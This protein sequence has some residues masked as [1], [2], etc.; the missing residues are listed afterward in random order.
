MSNF[1]MF[2]FD[3][4]PAPLKIRIQT[5]K[6]EN[7]DSQRSKVKNAVYWEIFL[8]QMA[9]FTKTIHTNTHTL[10]PNPIPKKA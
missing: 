8:I 3:H 5:W 10:F 9:S 4:I 2:Q 7:S 6:K 1:A